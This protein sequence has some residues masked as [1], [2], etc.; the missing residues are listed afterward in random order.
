M[1]DL[2]IAVGVLL[3]ERSLMLR[4]GGPGP[5]GGDRGTKPGDL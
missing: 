2:M 4:G 3:D 1:T 5:G